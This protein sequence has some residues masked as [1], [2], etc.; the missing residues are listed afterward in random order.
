MAEIMS[1]T[2]KN[3]G[4]SDKAL[5]AVN[6]LGYDLPTPVQKQA[7]PLILEGKDVIAAAKTGTG[8]TA[9]FAL[10]CMSHLGQTQRGKGPSL[11]VITP[12]RE[13]ALQIG[14]VCE[15]I[16]S[17]TH[18]RVTTIVGGVSYHPQKTQLKQG[19]DVLIATP[20][21]LIDLME[22]QALK[23]SDVKVLVL[24]E[25]DRMLDMG[26]WP[27]I[28]RIISEI[29]KNRQTLL[30]SATIDRTII[31]N[32][33][34]FFNDPEFV[35]IAHCG[36]T[37]DTVDQY[38]VRTPQAVKTDLL[39]A[40]L[41]EKGAERVIVFTRTKSRADSTTRRLRRAG[42]FADAIHSDR[43]QSQRE[44]ALKNFSKGKTSILVA[45]DVL[46]RG[47]DISEVGYVVNLD[48]PNQPEDYIH[49]IGRTGRAGVKGFSISFVCPEQ[50]AWLRDIEKL[51]KNKIP[52]ITI[53]GFDPVSASEAAAARATAQA[54]QKDPELATAVSEYAERVNKKGKSKAR[55]NA[56]GPKK[57]AK[58]RA[59]TTDLRPGRAQRAAAAR[60]SKR[61]SN[62]LS[63]VK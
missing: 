34:T 23:L 28:K 52:E 15:T 6:R 26:F 38:I 41:N 62:K 39:A 32:S 58:A 30:F 10:P 56:S 5:S 27:S 4:L 1:A 47:I 9:A 12:T 51:I 3:L 36:E 2:F 14:S 53:K 42:F 13:L 11:L 35:N 48:L 44:R 19:V 54:A 33:N 45:T 49:R 20:G 57:D 55:F 63:R 50:E 40:I 17:L 37:A 59:A 22:Q 43:S 24:D 29:P 31:N 46:A 25:A 8:K 21:R 7:I 61:N 16:A 60:K 18:H